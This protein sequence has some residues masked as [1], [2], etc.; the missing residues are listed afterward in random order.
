LEFEKITL[1]YLTL[2]KEIIFLF[3]QLIIMNDGYILRMKLTTISNI[4]IGI[5]VKEIKII[6]F[7]QQ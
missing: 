2:G 3:Y 4:A 7:I 6:K 5:Y 1:I